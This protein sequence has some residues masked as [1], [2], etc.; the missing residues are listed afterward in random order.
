MGLIEALYP[1]LESETAPRYAAHNALLAALPV[2]RA[3]CAELYLQLPGRSFTRT[4]HAGSCQG[5]A[6][7]LNAAVAASL[8][9]G[10]ID[11]PQLLI[12][13][14]PEGAGGGWTVFAPV[15][16]RGRVAGMIALSSRQLA[17]D[18]ASAA[19]VLFPLA[20]NLAALLPDLL[21]AE[22]ARQAPDLDPEGVPNLA[23]RCLGPFELAIDGEPLPMARFTRQKAIKALQYLVA[24]HGRPVSREALMEVLWPGADPRTSARNLRVILHDLRR[25]LDPGFT[26]FE[27]IRNAGETL[28]LDGTH[29]WV[30]AE[31]FV[32]AVREAE[33]YAGGGRGDLA[34]R[35]AARAFDLYRGDFLAGATITGGWAVICREQ[36]RELFFSA[37]RLSIEHHVRRGEFAAG[38]AVCWRGLE[39]EPSREDLHYW[40][41][42]LFADAGR[43]DDALRQYRACRRVLR[44]DLGVAPGPEIEALHQTLTHH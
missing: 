2:A 43:R 6:H 29:L 8:G 31:E 32:A 18:I 9:S 14:N 10:S 19:R 38:I 17:F 42:R 33:T 36:L 28:I 30:D 7:E 39:L 44:R 23:V 24:H 11:S 15:A 22:E 40:L 16:A 20:I 1:V 5:G 35:S 27:R 26:G 41:I 21:K 12:A 37:A 13:E 4:V 3:D 34:L 25:A